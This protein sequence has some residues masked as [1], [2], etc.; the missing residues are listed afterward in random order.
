MKKSPKIIK[1]ICD[2]EVHSYEILNVE[3]VE[4]GDLGNVK[5]YKIKLGEKL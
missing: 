1:L 2:K 4:N 3:I 5:Q